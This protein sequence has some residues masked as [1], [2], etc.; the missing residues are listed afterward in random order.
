MGKTAFIMLLRK[1][2]ETKTVGSLSE[3][4]L[5]VESAPVCVT[6]EVRFPVRGVNA[7]ASLSESFNCRVFGVGSQGGAVTPPSGR[8]Q[9]FSSVFLV[10]VALVLPCVTLW[11]R[12]DSPPSTWFCEFKA[13]EQQY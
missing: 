3:R 1:S 12:G 10:C 5:A 6:Q 9:A 13:R 2:L 11:S 7:V 4:V 8:V